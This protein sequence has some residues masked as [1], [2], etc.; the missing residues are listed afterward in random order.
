MMLCIHVGLST[1]VLLLNI[2][3]A[4]SS[5]Y[6]FD[7]ETYTGQYFAGSCSSVKVANRWIHLAINVLSSLLLLSSNYCMQILVAPTREEV[8]EKHENKDWFDIGVQS[9][10]NWKRIALRR[11]IVCV[12]LMVSS[13]LLHLM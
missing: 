1:A 9:W 11:R 4:A 8:D 3:F 10:R 13:A 2:G 5:I 6:N 12:I 7:M